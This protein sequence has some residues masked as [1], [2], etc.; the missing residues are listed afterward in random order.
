MTQVEASGTVTSG[1]NVTRPL[2]ITYL[3]K[4]LPL[5]SL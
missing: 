3:P 2:S 5:P 1:E 4:V